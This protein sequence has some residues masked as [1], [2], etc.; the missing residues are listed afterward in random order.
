[1]RLL[2][3]LPPLQKV[4]LCRLLRALAAPAGRA[5]HGTGPGGPMGMWLPTLGTPGASR[6]GNWEVALAGLCRCF[7]PLSSAA[8]YPSDGHLPGPE[9]QC[10]VSGRRT[11]PPGPL[12]PGS[13]E[14]DVCQCRYHREVPT[15]GTG[16]H[17]EPVILYT[18]PASLPS[19]G[20]LQLWGRCRH[21][22][23]AGE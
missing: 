17:F 8:R 4:L 2:Q 1:M 5:D 9:T 21:C 19:L 22:P 11:G 12:R 20:N 3:V 18:D 16:Q 13:L 23:P 14:D 7:S 15:L 10:G 6:A